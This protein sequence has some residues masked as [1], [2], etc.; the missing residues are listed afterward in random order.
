MGALLLLTTTLLTWGRQVLQVE[1]GDDGD[2]VVH[3]VRLGGRTLFDA[4]IEEADKLRVRVFPNGAR[5]ACVEVVSPTR[6]LALGNGV[7]GATRTRLSDLDALSRDV[8]AALFEGHGF[9]ADPAPPSEVE[10]PLPSDVPATPS[11]PD[12][13]E[14]R[15]LEPA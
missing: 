10:E 3:R 2:R 14:P 5:G 4:A 9:E 15:P 1:A 6:V 12:A 8:H 11:E 7:N 13:A